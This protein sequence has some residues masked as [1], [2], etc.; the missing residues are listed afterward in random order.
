MEAFHAHGFRVDILV[1]VETNAGTYGK[2]F[3]T[4]NSDSTM[5]MHE[6]GGTEAAPRYLSDFRTAKKKIDLLVKADG[7]IY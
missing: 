5:T 1:S 3:Q 4:E 6:K 2:V 7:D